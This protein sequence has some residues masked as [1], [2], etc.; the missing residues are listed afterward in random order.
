MHRQIGRLRVLVVEDEG[1]VALLLED[2]LIELGHEVVGPIAVLGKA[3]AVA[4]KDDVDIA[5]LDVNLNGLD[6][7]PVAAALA[8]RG[9]PFVFS[10]GYNRDRFPP[11]YRNAPMLQKPFQLNDLQREIEET[12]RAADA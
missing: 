4:S 3:V 6:T 10:T 7:F 12:Y 5:I 11:A 9:I 2:M 8:A 1:L